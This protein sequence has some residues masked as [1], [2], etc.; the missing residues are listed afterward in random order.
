MLKM[1]MMSGAPHGGAMMDHP[2]TMMMLN[3]GD[4]ISDRCGDT[5]SM[6][7]FQ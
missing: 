4:N 7:S 5:S 6:R 1:M 2:M 3:T